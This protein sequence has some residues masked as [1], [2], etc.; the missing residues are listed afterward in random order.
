MS[1]WLQREKE[2]LQ[3]PAETVRNLHTLLVALSNMDGLCSHLKILGN[4]LKKTVIF[5]T[6]FF[7]LGAV[8]VSWDP[9]SV[10]PWWQQVRITCIQSHNAAAALLAALVAHHAVKASITSRADTK[11]EIR[12]GYKVRL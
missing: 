3:K 6:F 7:V 12:G 10:S 5:F 2:V 4:W 8:E 9:Q 11:V 1:V